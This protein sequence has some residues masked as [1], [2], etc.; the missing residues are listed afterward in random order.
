MTPNRESCNSSQDTSGKLRRIEYFAYIM[1][2]MTAVMLIAVVIG[3]AGL[4]IG[5]APLAAPWKELYSSWED[6]LDMPD[7]ILQELTSLDA[8]VDNV[9]NPTRQR[10]HYTILVHQDELVGW[11]LLP[12]V[13][14]DG[15]LL[16]AKNSWNVDPPV[17]IL[18]EDAPRSTLLQEYLKRQARV[19]YHYSTTP[20]GYRSTLPAV[21]T[22]KQLLM[23]GD[24]VAFGDG[25]SDEFTMAS[26]LQ[27]LL[28]DSIQVVNAGVGG[29]SADQTLKV[30]QREIRNKH[31]EGLIY[32]ACHNDF[33]ENDGT[34]RLSSAKDILK[35]F[36]SLRAE[37]K[38]HIL[39]VF[40]PLLEYS[41]DHILHRQQWVPSMIRGTNDLRQR[42]LSECE[43]LGIQCLDGA[44]IMELHQQVA[45][46]IF[47]VFALYVDNAHLSPGGNQIF[48]KEIKLVV[49]GWLRAHP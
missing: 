13:R 35:D 36:S 7:P 44:E 39:V 32:I 48:A 47:S 31:F 21:Q 2:L 18:K 43:R 38:G 3:Y 17:V 28:G 8:V 41:M 4:K 20:D 37:Y 23:A 26:H 42:F 30:A 9:G 5:L 27:R 15:Y 14:L 45:S 1:G 40:V 10:D 34:V 25:V 22:Q 16:H 24:S 12:N 46:S 6:V 33:M 49:D 11:R 29:Y 19:R